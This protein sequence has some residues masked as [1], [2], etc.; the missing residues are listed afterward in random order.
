MV[1]EHDARY[2]ETDRGI[3]FDVDL[4]IWRFCVSF[5]PV[6]HSDS[7]Q[8]EKKGGATTRDRYDQSFGLEFY[9]IS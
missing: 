9:S 1:G 2:T 3:H 5:T 8:L 4:D 6:K 7:I